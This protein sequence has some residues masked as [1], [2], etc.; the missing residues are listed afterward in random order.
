MLRRAQVS[1]WTHQPAVQADGDVGSTMYDVEK[2]KS[3]GIPDAAKKTKERVIA[4]ED[5]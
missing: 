4:F 2:R 5:V 1:Q 3:R